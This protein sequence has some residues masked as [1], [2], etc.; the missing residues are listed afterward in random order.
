MP[1][2]YSF[3]AAKASLAGKLRHFSEQ[4]CRGEPPSFYKSRRMEFFGAS[5]V[6]RKDVLKPAVASRVGRAL[7]PS[8]PASPEVRVALGLL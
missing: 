4:N 7:Q 5:R 8:P 1:F 6:D 2:K 3:R